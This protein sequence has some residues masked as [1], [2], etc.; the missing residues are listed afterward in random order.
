M[1]KFF[2]MAIATAMFSMTAF[3]Q[4]GD[5]N[6]NRGRRQGQRPDMSKM[7][8]MRASQIANQLSLDDATTA[9]FT[10]IYK[11][12]VNDLQA[13][14]T[15]YHPRKEKTKKGDDKNSNEA[16]QG[17]RQRPER[18]S[19]TDKEVEERM[20]NG[21]KEKK[22]KIE[23]QENYYKKFRTIL[24]PKQIQ[25]VYAMGGNNGRKGLKGMNSKGGHQRMR[26]QFR[27]G[28]NGGPRMMPQGPRRFAW[29]ASRNN[30]PEDNS[31][32]M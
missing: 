25:K 21:F 7:T 32:Q 3:A 30:K 23:V 31:K 11:A 13:V 17:P 20:V 12:Y 26:S 8:E 28:K 14:N 27:G 2:L 24:N 10:E 1:K 4:Q 15:K 16:K 29:N 9:K 19:L 18:K 22:E 5:N 6:Q